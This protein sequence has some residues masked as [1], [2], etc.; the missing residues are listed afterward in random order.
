MKIKT[1]LLGLITATIFIPIV[2]IVSL[3]IYNH[4]N[5]TKRFLFDG[6]KKTQSLGIVQLSNNQWNELKSQIEK[7]PPEI[8]I[9]ALY[10]QVVLFSN[11][12]G[13]PS[14]SY[15]DYET[16]FNFLR[17]TNSNFKYQYYIMNYENE[18]QKILEVNKKNLTEKEKIIVISQFSEKSLH[19]KPKL[20][21]YILF[22][23]CICFE[24]F[25]ITVLIL[26]SK[27][28]FNSL[29]ILENSTKKIANGEFDSKIEV[30]TK[31]M[32]EITSLLENLEKMRQ[33]LK[34]SQDKKTK[35]IMGASHDLRTPVALIK[36]YSE[37]IKDEVVTDPEQIK[38]SVSIIHS[39]SKSLEE[40]I[41]DLINYVKLSN[42]DW[43]KLLEYHKAKEIFET[44]ANSLTGISDI[45]NRN[46]ETEIK[47]ADDTEIQ[48]DTNLLNRCVDNLV[49]NAL[50]YTN[51]GDTIYFKAIE[52]ES[53]E[54]IKFFV[55]DTGCG[56]KSEDLEHI[57]DLLYRG[58]N[59]RREEGFG[60]GLSV[61]KAIVESMKWNINVESERGKG[62][63]FVIT[64][65]TKKKN[66]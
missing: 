44:Y 14:G 53:E 65:P 60:I 63:V 6:L 55:G 66:L 26:L 30:K 3:P 49:S 19:K 47:I 42:S 56:I 52:N 39:E 20:S 41:N 33:S 34:E 25:S 45:Y 43:I 32:N 4:C 40:L 38:K 31:K 35:F 2:T 50:R 37:A 29:K 23:I 48:V 57:F 7:I 18:N 54:N 61:V 46:V 11:I 36:G 15:F 22:A 27:N 24:I 9:M 21:I 17:K 51:A 12:K 62:T 58:T 8:Q 16:L 13:F 28:I 59:S 5:S 64:I 10:K 1:Q